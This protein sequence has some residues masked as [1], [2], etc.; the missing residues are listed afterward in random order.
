MDKVI[1]WLRDVP[2]NCALLLIMFYRRC[3]S[4]LTS[5]HCRFYPTC[6]QYALTAFSRYGFWKGLWLTV[7]RISKCHP[8]HSGGY[9]PVP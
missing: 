1:G 5:A 3:I 6:S 7:K 8:F 4:P 9:D 2:K